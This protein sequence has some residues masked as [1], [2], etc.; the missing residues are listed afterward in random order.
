MVKLVACNL[1]SVFSCGL[2]IRLTEKLVACEF[3]VDVVAHVRIL[4][5]PCRVQEFLCIRSRRIGDRCR[6]LSSNYCYS[7]GLE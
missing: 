1:G 4:F 7:C 6:V 3:L 5:F 2:Q